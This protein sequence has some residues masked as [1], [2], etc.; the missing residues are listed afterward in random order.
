MFGRVLERGGIPLVITL[1]ATSIDAIKCKLAG[2]T[3]SCSIRTFASWRQGDAKQSAC[4]AHRLY[5]GGARD[6]LHL[7]RCGRR[8]NTQH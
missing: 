1:T 7:E 3:R 2:I 6:L 5:T 8:A 4:R